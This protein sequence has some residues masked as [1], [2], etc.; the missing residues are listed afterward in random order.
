MNVFQLFDVRTLLHGV[1]LPASHLHDASLPVMLLIRRTLWQRHSSPSASTIS[2]LLRSYHLPSA[3]TV[4]LTPNLTDDLAPLRALKPL[5]VNRLPPT[6]YH[7]LLLLATPLF[8]PSLSHDRQWLIAILNRLY[9]AVPELEFNLRVGVA[10]VDA[11]PPPKQLS[12]EHRLVSLNPPLPRSGFDGLAYLFGDSNLFKSFSPAGSNG[13]KTATISL[14]LQNPRQDKSYA[15]EVHVPLAN[16]TFAVGHNTVSM[17]VDFKKS[18]GQL[19][20]EISSV[21]AQNITVSWPYPIHSGGRYDGS[22]VL[23]APL[24]PLTIPRKILA[25]M[26]NVVRQISGSETNSSAV[27]ASSELEAAITSFFKTTCLPQSPIS[28][29]ALVTPVEMHESYKANIPL[30]S[31]G[32]PESLQTLWRSSASVSDSDFLPLL[33]QGAR[34]C[35]VLSG[36]GGWGQK[37]GLLALDPFTHVDGDESDQPSHF[38]NDPDSTSF[39]EA[40]LGDAA[41]VGDYIQFFISHAEGAK[42]EP[43]FDHVQSRLWSLHVGTIPSTID[44]LP[45]ERY[46][47]AKFHS[48]I[49]H[50]ISSIGMTLD[51]HDS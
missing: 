21:D 12:Q 15:Y 10:V 29:W 19:F 51:N 44:Q 4:R 48:T 31:R 42:V 28:V 38:P 26:G 23:S 32:S 6:S 8:A 3:A 22:V 27:P 14:A 30:H 49:F 41:R 45:T 36:G 20:R 18:T 9:S 13:N 1:L 5:A 24:L 43:D 11:L 17:V 7:S 33:E 40:I 16:T 25:G 39:G 37:A 47:R 35:R 46:V 50:R 34:L 2:G